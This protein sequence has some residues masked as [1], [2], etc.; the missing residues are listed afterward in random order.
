MGKANGGAGASESCLPCAGNAGGRCS[1]AAL[2]DLQAFAY[3]QKDK[4]E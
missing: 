3:C 4:A 2:P 1:G